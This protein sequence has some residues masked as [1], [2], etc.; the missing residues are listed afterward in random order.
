MSENEE[1]ES[2]STDAGEGDKPKATEIIKQQS[3]RIKELEK[4]RD[5][6]IESDA[7]KQ[8]GGTTEGGKSSEKDKKEENDKEYRTRIDKEL[9]EGKTD[10]GN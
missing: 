6:R 8:L 10:F 9:A 2:T 3:E 1:K 7:K 5:E 4:E